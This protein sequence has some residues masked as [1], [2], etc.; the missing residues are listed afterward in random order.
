MTSSLGPVDLCNQALAMIAAR[1]NITS[2]APSDGTVAGDACALLYQSTVDAF[3]RAAHWN[4]LRFTAQLSLLKAA[5]G[6]PEN[7]SGTTL[8]PAPPPWLYEYALPPDCLKARFLVPLLPQQGTSPPLTTGTSLL[9]PIRAGVTALPFTPAVDLDQEGN[10][11]AVLLTNLGAFSGP[12]SLVYTR[13]LLNIGLWDAQF[14]MGAK[15]A[16]GSWL[17]MPVNASASMLGQAMGIA[18][19]TLDAARLSD[20]NEGPQS[21]DHEAEW[22]AGRYGRRGVGRAAGPFVAPWDSFGFPNGVFY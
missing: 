7:I 20:A 2:I 21:Q 4:C 17:V 22:I 1:A 13:R 5:K 15:A 8:P 12:P 18:K 19:A 14:F 3:A 10:E 9:T 16:L 11:I 6:T